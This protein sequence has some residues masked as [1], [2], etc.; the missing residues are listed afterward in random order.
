MACKCGHSFCYKCGGKWKNYEEHECKKVTYVRP[1]S[2]HVVKREL[3]VRQSYAVNVTNLTFVISGKEEEKKPKGH[4][5][6][7]MQA[8][9]RSKKASKQSSRTKATEGEE[10][11]VGNLSQV[12]QKK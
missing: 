5:M 11:L 9:L 10:V 4:R 1:R 8:F 6:P 2:Y 7:L 3:P 12:S